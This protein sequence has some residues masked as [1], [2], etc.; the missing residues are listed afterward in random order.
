MLNILED[1][2]ED[3]MPTHQ[4]LELDRIKEKIRVLWKQIVIAH[5]E[6]IGIPEQDKAHY[7]EEHNL[8]F[9][10]DPEPEAS[11]VDNLV[12]LLDNLLMPD[13]ALQ[14]IKKGGKAPAYKGSGLSANKEPGKTG[15]TVY[16]VS[17]LDTKTPSDKQTKARSS[18][19]DRPTGGRISFRKDSKVKEVI[20]PFVAHMKDKLLSLE[21]R[22]TI[23]RRRQLFR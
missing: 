20:S 16:E 19:Y 12:E 2:T 5:C 23:G 4:S 22:Q 15:V 18:G 9:S 13:E 8:Y 6:E 21:D 7:I 1:S 17:H 14:P 11:E 10:G 3:E